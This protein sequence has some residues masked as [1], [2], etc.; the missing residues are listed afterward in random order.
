[1][2]ESEQIRLHAIVKGRVQ[3][4]GFR[5][6]VVETGLVLGA[7]GWA[8]NHWDGSVEVVAEGDQKT[9]EDLLAAL[10]RGPRISRVSQ[11][12]QDWGT[13]TGEFSTFHVKST[14]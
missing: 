11:V 3:G 6:F 7:T 14:F 2:S 8:R 1:M 10:R 5:A 12:E 13:A 9:L 4:V